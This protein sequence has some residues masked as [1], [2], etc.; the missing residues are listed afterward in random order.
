M[1]AAAAAR[2]RGVEGHVPQLPGR[3][4]GAPQEHPVGD[5]SAADPGA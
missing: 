4:L 5:D 3:S 2:S 1:V